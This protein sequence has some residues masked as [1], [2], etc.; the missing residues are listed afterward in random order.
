MG[1]PLWQLEPFDERGD[2]RGSAPVAALLKRAFSGEKARAQLES[3]PGPGCWP[4]PRALLATGPGTSQ[5][6]A[7]PS[8]QA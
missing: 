5:R 7:R 2:G 6:P 8:W 1:Q 4:R 3:R